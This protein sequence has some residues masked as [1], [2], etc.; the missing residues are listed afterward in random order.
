M[1]AMACA[2]ISKKVVKVVVGKRVVTWREDDDGSV[3]VISVS[4]S[5]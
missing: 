2:Q 3:V 5:S 4:T 1:V